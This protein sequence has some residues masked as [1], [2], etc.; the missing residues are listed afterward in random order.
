MPKCPECGEYMVRRTAG[1]GP[2]KGR[3]FWG[4]SDYPDCYGTLSIGRRFSKPSRSS[5]YSR[6]SWKDDP[7][8][9]PECGET[10]ERKDARYGEHAGEEFWGCSD[11]P[12]C[13]GL[14]PID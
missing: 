2:N 3:D 7:P 14:I 12:D 5:S 9:C 8:D 6:P 13:R 1:R 10:M 11:F 4:C